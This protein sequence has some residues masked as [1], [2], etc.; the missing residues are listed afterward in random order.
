MSEKRKSSFE[1]CM[2]MVSAG[3]S[4]TASAANGSK[5]D[6][7][8]LSKL[9]TE[10][11]LGDK[12]MEKKA[13]GEAVVPKQADATADVTSAAAAVVAATDAVAMPQVVAQGGDAAVVAA[14]EQPA[15]SKPAS[16]DLLISDGAGTVTDANAV[17]KTDAAVAAAARGVGGAESGTL[18]TAATTKEAALIGETIAKSFQATIEKTAK[19]AEYAECLAF[20]KEA[21]LLEGYTIN[22]PAMEKTAAVTTGFLAK[23]A[24]KKPLS[25]DDIIGA[26]HE[27][28]ALE[29]QAADADA[30]GRAE[31][32]ALV[33]LLTK[34]AGD[35]E[36][37]EETADEKAAREKKEHEDAETA[38]EEKKEEEKVAALL[39]N[40]KV[41]DAIRTLK[42]FNVL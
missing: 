15:A 7:S 17:G 32:H 36:A 33:D 23:I 8:L 1:D 39:K 35:E 6:D 3:H 14:G 38:A 40:P 16:P 12:P 41:V 9:A 4:K 37:K 10:L 42:G 31:A 22:T 27:Y 21:G 18:D 25:T 19:A 20:C 30:E 2:S 28:A 24:S 11:G 34:I 29:K 26:A 13:E 5:V